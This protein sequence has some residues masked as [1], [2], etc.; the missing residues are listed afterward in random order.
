MLYEV[1]TLTIE[2]IQEQIQLFKE[3]LPFVEI[4]DVRN[5]FV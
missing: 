5:N 3:G 4:K 2:K 1:I